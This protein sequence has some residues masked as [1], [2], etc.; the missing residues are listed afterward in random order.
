MKKHIVAV[1][2]VIALGA[3]PTHAQEDTRWTAPS[4][5]WSIDHISQGWTHASSL[6]PEFQHFARIMIPLEP[7]PDNEV[8]LC[9]ISEVRLDQVDPDADRVR[10]TAA[11]L[12][13][14]AATE[15]VAPRNQHVTSISNHEIGGVSVADIATLS[16]D[17]RRA[18][19][20]RVFY[21]P[22]NAGVT[23]VEIDCL[24]AASLDPAKAAEIPAILGTLTINSV[25]GSQ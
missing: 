16:N 8:R 20:H 15:M 6:P 18:H 7:P 22:L 3:S 21:L 25:S 23:F 19:V 10:S 17:G 4:G 2:A 24:W 13:L 12:D 9:S 1:L 5:A 14:E 11:R